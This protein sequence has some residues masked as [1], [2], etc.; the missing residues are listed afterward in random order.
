[1]EEYYPQG[2]RRWLR[3]HEKG[4]KFHEVRA[5]AAEYR[6]AH[7]VRAGT[8]DRL[9]IRFLE[10]GNVHV[11]GNLD[12]VRLS[13]KG[14][15]LSRTT[16]EGDQ[17]LARLRM[18]ESRRLTAAVNVPASDLQ[19]TP[20]LISLLESPPEGDLQAAYRETEDH[21]HHLQPSI[22]EAGEGELHQ[23]RQEL[24]HLAAGVE[25][26]AAG[27]FEDPPRV[28][29]LVAR[30]K[31]RVC[32][33]RDRYGLVAACGRAVALMD[34]AERISRSEGDHLGVS[35]CAELR[36][37]VEPHQASQSISG[38]E[39]V[40]EQATHFYLR[41]AARKREHRETH[42]HW[43]ETMRSLASNLWLYTEHLWK[44]RGRLRRDNL[45][46]TRLDVRE[47]VYCPP[48]EEQQNN[49]FQGAGLTL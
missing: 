37:K 23:A 48:Q 47:A 27:K 12:P 32:S 2:K 5:L 7:E 17:V 34:H 4:G 36:A 21:L 43:L 40:K 14:R 28:A 24:E 15:E 9:I 31:G 49:R 13:I 46:G 18:D 22:N 42:L 39:R 44:A 30:L 25:G 29:S 20:P 6:A 35:Q 16:R 19:F 33:L 41:H 10:G 1:M 11:E 38:L 45:E 26:I 8:P 3:L